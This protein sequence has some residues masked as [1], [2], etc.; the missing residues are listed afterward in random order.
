MDLYPVHFIFIRMKKSLLH[1]PCLYLP[2][3]SLFLATEMI[4]TLY[5]YRIE[6]KDFGK[7]IGQAIQS[8]IG[9][10]INIV[11][12]KKTPYYLDLTKKDSLIMEYTLKGKHFR[13]DT[14]RKAVI[15]L[16]DKMLYDFYRDSWNLDSMAKHFRHFSPWPELSITFTRQDSDGKIIDRYPA[17]RKIPDHSP[18]IPPQQLGNIFTDSLSAWFHLPLACF[19]ERQKYGLSLSLIPLLLALYYGILIVKKQRLERRN[20]SL[21]EKQTV[22]I[23]DLKTPLCTNRDIE[24]RIL[25]NLSNWETGKILQKLRIAGRQS[26]ELLS[27]M[28]KLTLRSASEW[29]GKIDNRTFNLKEAI[30]KLIAAHRDANEE[31]RIDLDFKMEEAE[32]V[33]DPF[34]LLHIIDNLV[35]NA[36][37]HAGRPVRIVVTCARDKRERL[38]ISVKDNGRGIPERLQKNIFKTGFRIN[39]HSDN[40]GIGLAYIRKIVRQ[41]KGYFHVSSKEN[42]G[43]TFSLALDTDTPMKSK[44]FSLSPAIY[45]YFFLSILLSDIIWLTNLYSA[46]R[47]AFRNREGIL[48]DEAVLD[49]SKDAFRWREDTTYFKNNWAEKTITIVRNQKDTTMPMG[50]HTNQGYVYGH[51]F[52]DLRDTWWSIDSIDG[53]Y[54]KISSNRHRAIYFRKDSSG[55]IIDRYPANA[56]AIFMPVIFSMPLGFVEGHRL[57]V[58]LAYPWMLS[59]HHNRGWLIIALASVLLAGWFSYLLYRLTKRQQAIVHLQREKVQHFI[60]ELYPQ[61]EQILLSE[62]NMLE[63]AEICSREPLSAHLENNIRNY[64]RMLEKINDLLNRIVWM[65]VH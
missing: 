46:E 38:L 13:V 19:W 54:R 34:H 31:L 57:E 29:G 51:M 61:L 39:P 47:N 27:E 18:N 7:Q 8:A 64:E 22:F 50:T 59:F 3:L 17:G 52:Y 48:L 33:A 32:I 26:T 20:N 23:H 49:H 24:K 35:G 42:E 10:E 56:P 9:E 14:I 2:L 6:E 45:Y 53:P 11:K 25:K 36:V 60:R 12:K 30:E 28:E 55:K 15:D 5:L 1:R 63:Q 58:Q 62:K 4:W 44:R 16:M 37:K 43:T 65:R 40:H 41:Y 21:L